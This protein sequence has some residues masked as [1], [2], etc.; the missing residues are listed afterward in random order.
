MKLGL[1]PWPLRTLPVLIFHESKPYPEVG[2]NNEL[3]LIVEKSLVIWI[4]LIDYLHTGEY[5]NNDTHL[6]P[7]LG[8]KANSKRHSQG[9]KQWLVLIP[10]AIL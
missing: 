9:N 3:C 6:A 5:T 2:R 7:K 8:K 4:N 1:P 10:L